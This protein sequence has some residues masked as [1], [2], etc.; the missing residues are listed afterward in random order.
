MVGCPIHEK[1]DSC[2]AVSAG[3]IQVGRG[4]ALQTGETAYTLSGNA[5]ELASGL[6]AIGGGTTTITTPLTLAGNQ[7]M[8]ASSGTLAVNAPLE[9]GSH[10][11]TVDAAAGAQLVL[12]QEISGSG[13]LVKT[14][15]RFS[16][17]PDTR[18]P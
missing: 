7:G 16:M 8:S 18:R 10:T 11:L 9:L 2:K 4:G 17:A 15:A 3:S 12:Q 5:L 6:Q 14:A 1:L 13:S